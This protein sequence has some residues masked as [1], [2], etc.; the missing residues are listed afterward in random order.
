V[1][2]EAV[3]GATAAPGHFADSVT[4]GVGFGVTA[5]AGAFGDVVTGY[6]GTVHIS[7]PA[8]TSSLQT[9]QVTDATDNA[10]LGS[11]VVGVLAQRG[12]RPA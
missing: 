2:R 10:M 9:L 3:P 12:G 4:Q 8:S 1:A 6:T 7:G 11:G 5:S